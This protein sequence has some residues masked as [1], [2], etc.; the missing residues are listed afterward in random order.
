MTTPACLCVS[1]NNEPTICK[2]I[3][4]FRVSTAAPETKLMAPVPNGTRPFPPS[5]GGKGVGTRPFNPIMG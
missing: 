1:I 5:F 4:V 2:K 3:D